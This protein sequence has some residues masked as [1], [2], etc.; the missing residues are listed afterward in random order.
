M[1]TVAHILEPLKK[2][3]EHLENLH[4]LDPENE[5]H[6]HSYLLFRAVYEDCL[7]RGR[8]YAADQPKKEAAG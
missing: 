2:Q 7:W 5:Q 3:V 1:K 8:G 4:K 6:E